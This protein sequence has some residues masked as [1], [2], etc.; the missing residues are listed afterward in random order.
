[1]K[2]SRLSRVVLWVWQEAGLGA[3]WVTALRALPSPAR[4]WLIRKKARLRAAIPA[5]QVREQ[6]LYR[7]FTDALLL[8]ADSQTSPGAYLEFGV[9]R[10]ASFACMDRASRDLGLTTMRLVGFD[11][12]QGL[13]AAPAA[14]EGRVWAPGQ[15]KSSATATREWLTTQGVDW[16]RSFLV[17]G[18]FDDTLTGDLEPM[19]GIESVS[20]V[21]F[22]CDLYSS[23]KVALEFV[24]PLLRDRAV[25][26]FDDWKVAELDERN[27]GEKRAFDEFL[28]AH[29]ELEVS[30]L[31]PYSSHTSVS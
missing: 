12:F 18:W 1:V 9:Y 17:E 27:L 3:A 19:R 25:L 31:P 4:R 11:S 22:D 21:M 8:T 5:L 15:F 23:T 14:A 26:L 28:A 16:A 30:D 6:A 29:P 13:P 7:T 24:E 2:D 10:G 20:V